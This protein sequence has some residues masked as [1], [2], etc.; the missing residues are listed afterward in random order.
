MNENTGKE[1]K[2]YLEL[3]KH[4]RKARQDLHLTQQQLAD[5]LEL[6]RTSIT[7]IEKGKQKILAYMLVEF[8]SKLKVTVDDLLPERA[9]KAEEAKI[10]NLLKNENS[11]GKREFLESVLDKIRGG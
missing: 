3:G 4:I 9:S 8:A 2:F 11:P 1:T 7:N 6:N 10:D 5:L